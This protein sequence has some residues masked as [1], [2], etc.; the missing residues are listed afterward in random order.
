M[1]VMKLFD[2]EE[3]VPKR[4]EAIAE[5]VLDND[6]DETDEEHQLPTTPAPKKIVAETPA[7]PAIKAAKASA[8]DSDSSLASAVIRVVNAV[9]KQATV[10]SSCL[11]S[12]IYFFYTLF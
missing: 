10:T 12:T 7:K 9:E 5:A 11:G 4:L 2:H 8:A 3:E 6:E 1:N